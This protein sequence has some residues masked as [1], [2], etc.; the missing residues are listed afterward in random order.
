MTGFHGVGSLFDLRARIKLQNRRR[1]SD[2][3]DIVLCMVATAL[4]S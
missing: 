3:I 4:T 2:S 1:V